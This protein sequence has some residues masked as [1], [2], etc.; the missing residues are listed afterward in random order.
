MSSHKLASRR[1]A[2]HAPGGTDCSAT[3][4]SPPYPIPPSLSLLP[5]SPTLLPFCTTRPPHVHGPVQFSTKQME[6]AAKKC[7]KDQKAQQSKVKKVSQ[8]RTSTS[9]VLLALSPSPPLL[10]SPTPL[11]PLSSPPSPPL[12]PLPYSA[13]RLCSKV[14]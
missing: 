4:S 12:P 6:R 14:M 11:P 3:S 8:S 5:S 10:P 7:E 9:Y 1:L 2:A 13:L